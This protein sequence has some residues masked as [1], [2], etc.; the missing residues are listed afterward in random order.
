[1]GVIVEESCEC[2]YIKEQM[3]GHGMNDAKKINEINS[4][5][6]NDWQNPD[7][8]EYEASDEMKLC[9]KCKL[10]FLRAKI[11]LLFD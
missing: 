8:L 3:I 4:N 6:L 10:R 7:P 1:M 9:P 11:V 5:P 2:G